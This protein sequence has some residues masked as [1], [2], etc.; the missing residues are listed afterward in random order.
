MWYV[1]CSSCGNCNAAYSYVAN[2]EIINKSV[3]TIGNKGGIFKY[4]MLI[5]FINLYNLKKIQ[6]FYMK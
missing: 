2:I 3:N 4:I 1:T 6:T 5:S